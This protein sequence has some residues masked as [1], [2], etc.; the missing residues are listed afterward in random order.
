MK[1]T[2][3][4]VVIIIVVLGGGYYVYTT[5]MPRDAE[6][7]VTDPSATS[8]ATSTVQAQE[9]TVGDGREATPN[10]L[11]SVLYAG[12]LEDGTVFDSSEAH[13]D[14]ETGEVLPLTF[15][16]GTPDLIPGFQLGV[17]GMKVGGERL[18]AV[19]SALGYGDQDLKDPTGKVVIPAN[20]TLVFRIRLVDVQDAPTPDAQ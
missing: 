17:N 11:V 10:S 1:T 8:N 16:L 18:I 2:I 7:P 15:V 14:P 3:I 4:W 20:S 5:Y 9:V 6:D 12:Q 13:A 19:P